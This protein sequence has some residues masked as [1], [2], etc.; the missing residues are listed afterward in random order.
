MD[1]SVEVERV[2]EVTSCSSRSDR[3]WSVTRHAGLRGLLDSSNLT[4]CHL[5]SAKF[6]VYL[7]VM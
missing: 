6:G 1:F 3:G 7:D 5:Q 4:H 2:D